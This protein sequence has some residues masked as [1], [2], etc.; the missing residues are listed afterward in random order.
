MKIVKFE[1][2]NYAVRRWN[3]F[4]GYEF[5]MMVNGLEL[6][7]SMKGIGGSNAPWIKVSSLIAAQDRVKHIKHVKSVNNDKGVEA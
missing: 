1:D 7:A 2:G 6:W 3:W 4:F 5:Y